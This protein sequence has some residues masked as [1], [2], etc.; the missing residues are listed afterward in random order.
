VYYKN[1]STKTTQWERPR[2]ADSE[3]ANKKARVEAPVE[4]RVRHILIKHA[5]SR[6]PASWRSEGR[7]VTTTKQEAGAELAEIRLALVATR[8][9]NGALQAAFA[10]YAEARS[11]CSSAKPGRGGDLGSFPHGRMQP[12]FEKIA[13]ALGVGELSEIVETDSG[14]HLILRTA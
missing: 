12:P 2:S 1:H 14:L 13:F 8:G 4:V 5:A 3:V 7:A 10:H 6:K 11:E 9:E